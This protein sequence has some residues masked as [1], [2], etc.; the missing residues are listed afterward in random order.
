[1]Q[2][3]S[4]MLGSVTARPLGTWRIVILL[5]VLVA[6]CNPVRGCAESYF[7]LAPESRLPRWFTLASEQRRSDVAV[8][9]TYYTGLVGGS[10]AS[11][12]LS[13]RNGRKL[14]GV[15]GPVRDSQPQT[16]TAAPPTGPLPYPRYEFV[17]ING[18]TEVVEHR[19]MEPVF[20]ISDDP[21][22]RRKLGVPN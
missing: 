6:A 5:A 13:D 21:E 9:M 20:Y 3:V 16:L 7:R 14:A 22:V 17:T 12:V 2:K 11:F 8:T 18:I 10:T 4:G 1:M 19:R 15:E